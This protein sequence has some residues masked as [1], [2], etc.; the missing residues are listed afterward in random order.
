MPHSEGLRQ[1][2]LKPLY[3]VIVE[4]LE[5]YGHHGVSPEEQTVGHQFRVNATVLLQSEIPES[6][7]VADTIDYAQL[8][9]LVVKTGTERRYKTV[10]ALTATMGKHI[11]EAFPAAL[12]VN[13]YVM[14]MNPPFPHRAK[15]AG[16]SVSLTRKGDDA[17]PV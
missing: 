16:V 10:E 3:S 12:V 14:K 13:L 15:S 7:D 5:F 8:A 2:K 17:C 11:F 9:D 1:A 6:D 4:D